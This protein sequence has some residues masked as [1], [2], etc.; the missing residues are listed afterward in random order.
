MDD[1]L[2]LRMIACGI[3]LEEPYLRSHLSVLMRE[4]QKSLKSGKLPV[5]E[6][7]YLMGTV[8]PTGTLKANEVC[9]ILY[10]TYSCIFFY[11][12]CHDT[13]EFF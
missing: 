13:Q 6:C 10:V 7:Y 3:P 2:A 9:V 4:E 11:I 1:F 5:S 12:Y 8:D